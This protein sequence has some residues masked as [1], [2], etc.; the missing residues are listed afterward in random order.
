MQMFSNA[1]TFFSNS[2]RST[3][4]KHY[5]NVTKKKKHQTVK[6]E[7]KSLLDFK[8]YLITSHEH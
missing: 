5:G 6:E 1:Y 7:Y 2:K 8:Q 3:N 4:Q